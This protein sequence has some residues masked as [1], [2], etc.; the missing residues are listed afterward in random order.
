VQVLA[1]LAGVALLGAAAFFATNPVLLQLGV[2]S[3]K[4]R[5]RRSRPLNTDIS[6]A[7]LLQTFINKVSTI[8]PY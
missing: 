3:G 1:P 7:L 5:R 8:L 2:I 4:R 6:N